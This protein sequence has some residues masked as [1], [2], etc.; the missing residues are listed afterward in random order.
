MRISDWSSDV[1]SSDLVLRLADHLVLLEN[2]AVRAAGPLAD[3]AAT[4]GLLPADEE[5]HEAGAV[6]AATVEAHDDAHGLT[7]LTARAGRIALPRLPAAPG[8]AVRLRIR[9]RDKD[10]SASCRESVCQYVYISWGA[11]CLKTK[12]EPT[13]PV[14][15]T[16]ITQSQ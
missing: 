8:T 2:G 7:W 11:V 4:P 1:C 5:G 9:P 6:I 16:H 12:I 3:L 14:N 13:T 15:T 10:G